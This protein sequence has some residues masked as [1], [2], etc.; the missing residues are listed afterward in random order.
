MIV[1]ILMQET[2]QSLPV[3]VG[4]ERANIVQRSLKMSE[5]YSVWELWL[6]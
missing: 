5:F 4:H 2:L 3:L 1:N 6:W